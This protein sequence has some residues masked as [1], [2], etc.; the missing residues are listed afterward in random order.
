MGAVKKDGHYLISV[1]LGSG[2]YPN[3]RYKWEDTKTDGL[4]N[5]NYNK[6]EIPLNQGIPSK[7]PVKNGRK[8]TCTLSAPASTSLY[9]SLRK[10]LA[11]L[12]A[13]PLP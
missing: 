8:S 1:V 7:L 3:R 13:C 5:K 2:W 12:S 4:W 10:K 6:K 11:V 9:I